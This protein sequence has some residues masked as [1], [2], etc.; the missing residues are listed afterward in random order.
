ML[1]EKLTENIG[2]CKC[3]VDLKTNLYVII[4]Y[5]TLVG[6]YLTKTV[7]SFK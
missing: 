3:V 4:R 6:I 7:G 2:K 5:Y 1:K